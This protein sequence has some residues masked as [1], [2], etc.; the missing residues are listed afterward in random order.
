MTGRPMAGAS[1]S[2][3]VDLV[4]LERLR[5]VLERYGQR[6]VERVYTPEEAARFGG[7]L[8]ELAARFAA[9]EAVSKALG[10]G[11]RLLSPNGIGW[12]D[13]AVL[14]DARGKPLLYLSG[15]ALAL[16]EEQGLD[17]WAI[18]LTHDRDYALAFVVAQGAQ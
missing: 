9:K 16:A 4:E 12:R 6:F 2:V 1:L 15:R 17:R 3:G 18:S 13:V 10:V 7:H 14:P 8:P 11:M 5:R